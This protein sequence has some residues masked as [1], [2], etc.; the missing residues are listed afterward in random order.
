MKKIACI[1][2]I[3]GLLLV[4][5]EPATE[6]NWFVVMF[7]KTLIGSACWVVSVKLLKSSE[8]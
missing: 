4:V 7:F 1:L 5:S 6:V 8:K 3:V 2:F